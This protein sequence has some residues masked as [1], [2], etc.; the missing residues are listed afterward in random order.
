MEYFWPQ[1]SPSSEDNLRGVEADVSNEEAI[2]A[3]MRFNPIF[4][5]YENISTSF[6]L[7]NRKIFKEQRIEREKQDKEVIWKWISQLKGDL[8]P[9]YSISYKGSEPIYLIKEKQ[10]SPEL[11]WYVIFLSIPLIYCLIK[12]LKKIYHSTWWDKIQTRFKTLFE[13]YIQTASKIINFVLK[14]IPKIGRIVIPLAAIAYL[15]RVFFGN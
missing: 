3:F 14:I 7:Q 13:K 2:G 4:T 9:K 1:Y 8:R 15:Y 5:L 10:I 11:W 12:L 6:S